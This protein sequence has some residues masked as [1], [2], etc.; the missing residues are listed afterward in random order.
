MYVQINQC[1]CVVYHTA[2]SN[3]RGAG[4]TKGL[5]DKTINLIIVCPFSRNTL[6]KKNGK[7]RNF[8]RQIRCTWKGQFSNRDSEDNTHRERLRNMAFSKALYILGWE[9]YSFL[10]EKIYRCNK[11]NTSE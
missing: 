3:M 4:D 11:I 2:V 6:N 9:I 8:T 5:K 10:T 1:R 7:K